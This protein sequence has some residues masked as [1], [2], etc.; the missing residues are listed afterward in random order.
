M[1]RTIRPPL[2]SSSVARALAVTLGSASGLGFT[3]GDGTDDAAVSFTGTLTALNAALG[4]HYPNFVSDRLFGVPT[5]VMPYTGALKSWLYYPVFQLF[6]VSVTS[7][8]HPSSP[9]TQSP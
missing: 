6:G 3:N 9:P 4:G 1:P 5:M 7:V 2:I 8:S